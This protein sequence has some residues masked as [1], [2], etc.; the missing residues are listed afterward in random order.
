MN[1][2]NILFFLFPDKTKKSSTNVLTDFQ[3]VDFSVSEL[4]TILARE[5]DL[6]DDQPDSQR[7]RPKIGE[8][9]DS[10]YSSG[11]YNHKLF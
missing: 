2:F 5:F 6:E 1:R 8:E 7:K 9:D 4:P 11:K 3:F 10:R